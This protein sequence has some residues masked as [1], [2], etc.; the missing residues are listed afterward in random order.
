M[1]T[2][3]RGGFRS[4]VKG[5]TGQAGGSSSGGRRWLSNALTVAL[6]VVAALM[7]ARRFGLLH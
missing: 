6:L 4:A 3:M 5:A 7:L 2:S 1:L